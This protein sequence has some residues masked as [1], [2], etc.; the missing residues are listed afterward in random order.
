MSTFFAVRYD[1]RTPGA[2]PTE[3]QEVYARSL[4]QARYVDEQ[5]HDVLMLSEHHAS[6][7]GYLPS[8]L[9]V[10]SAMAAVTTRIPITVAALLVN[11]YEPLRLAEDIAV[12]D[13]LSGGRVNYTFGLGYRPEEYALYGRDWST[14]GRDVEERI[15]V[16]LQAWTGAE[17]EH[18]GRRVRVTPTPF[19]QPHPMLFYGGGTPAAARRAGRLGLH[20]QP[21]HGDRAL[22]EIYE[23][24]C[25]DAGRDPGLV[26]RPPSGPANVFCT[27]DVD[28][29]WDRYGHHLLADAVAYQEWHG[30]AASHVLD[31]S[32]T[33]EEMRSAGVYVVAT[34]DE[35]IDR[36]R[37]GELRLITSH[38][39]CGGLPSEPSWESLRL[40]S[41]TVL[42][43]VR[44]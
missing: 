31:P 13:H 15:A 11:F 4:E 41:E 3:R 10:A 40:I 24:A 17:F 44:A 36:S 38:P 6:D 22:Q 23:T 9:P 42:P 21:Q 12:L 37:S 35:L 2:T 28:A 43:A 26:M 5:G 25:R 14:R 32:R 34:A 30:K 27:R 39:A 20:F 1:F 33:V 16:L 29:F 8:P 18:E 19:S 7:D